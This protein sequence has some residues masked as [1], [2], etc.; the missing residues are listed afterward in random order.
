VLVLAG[1]SGGRGRSGSVGHEGFVLVDGLLGLLTVLA[2][3]K[4]EVGTGGHEGVFGQIEESAGDW[5]CGVVAEN[6]ELV[7]VLLLLL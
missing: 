5:R 1:S 2:F 6:L 7:M 4:E 3:G